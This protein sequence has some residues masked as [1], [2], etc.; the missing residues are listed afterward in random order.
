MFISLLTRIRHW[1]ESKACAVRSR[2]LFASRGRSY[3]TCKDILAVKQSSRQQASKHQ[4]LIPALKSNSLLK[5]LNSLSV[6]L[7]PSE[8]HNDFLSK[9]QFILLHLWLV[10]SVSCHFCCCRDLLLQ[11]LFAVYSWDFDGTWSSQVQNLLFAGWETL[12][13]KTQANKLIPAN[14]WTAG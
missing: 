11:N 8:S 6:S 12:W 9:D 1:A 10:S 3:R 2:S 5:V 4:T 7:W 14:I 13:R